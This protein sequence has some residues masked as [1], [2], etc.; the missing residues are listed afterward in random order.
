MRTNSHCANSL[1][2]QTSLFRPTHETQVKEKQ[3][4]FS[5][6]FSMLVN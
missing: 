5:S 4:V 2:T 6:C 1:L 3:A